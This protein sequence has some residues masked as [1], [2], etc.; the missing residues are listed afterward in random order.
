MYFGLVIPLCFL[1]LL[2]LQDSV[3]KKRKRSPFSEE[4]VDALETLYHKDP[5]PSMAIKKS[6]AT[7]M[8]LEINQLNRWF[9]NRRRKARRSGELPAANKSKQQ[10]IK[11]MGLPSGQ[12]DGN[13]HCQF[14]A[15]QQKSEVVPLIVS[16]LDT[17]EGRASMDK[18]EELKEDDLNLLLELEKEVELL[19]SK[20]LSG[21]LIPLPPEGQ[22]EITA[23]S[24]SRL[25]ALIAG[26]TKPLSELVE[27]LLPL[28]T[29]DA[30]SPALSP[31]ELRTNILNL[32]ARK[33]HDVEERKKAKSVQEQLEARGSLWQWELRDGGRFLSKIQRT[34]AAN[35]KR[36][37]H[38]VSSRMST[39]CTAI[40]IIKKYRDGLC[41]YEVVKKTVAS[42][43]KSK[44]FEQLQDA[45][46]AE[47]AALQ[48]K[49]EILQRDKEL[50]ESERIKQAAAKEKLRQEKEKE[51][52]LL[53][54]Q[55][56][57]ERER[58]RLQKEEEK[59]NLRRQREEEKEELRRQKEEERERLK[60]KREEEKELQRREKEKEKERK[61]AEAEAAK[62]ARKTGFK[63]A[64][65]LS[66]TAN[67][68][69]SFFSTPSSVDRKEKCAAREP[70]FDSSSKGKDKSSIH[71]R[72]SETGSC[73]TK[74]EERFPKPPTDYL[75]PRPILE[76]LDDSIDAAHGS[77]ANSDVIESEWN[78][79]V[80]RQI[81]MRKKKAN[82]P[83]RTLGL[84]PSWARYPDAYEAA[85]KRLQYVQESGIDDVPTWRRKLLQFSD[86][87]R[88][89]YYGSWHQSRRVVGPR[90]PF[91]RD[92]NIDYE[93]MSD[94]EW[95]E[96]PED[97]DD[98]GNSDNEEENEDD[99]DD[100]EQGSFM[101]EDGYLSESEGVKLDVEDL[102][103]DFEGADSR[104]YTGNCSALVSDQRDDLRRKGYHL[105][106][107]QLRRSHATGKPL[108]I[109]R[110][111]SHDTLMLDKNAELVSD[112]HVGKEKYSSTIQGDLA[113]L[114]ALSMEVLNPSILIEPP[115]EIAHDEEN[116]PNSRKSPENSA[117]KAS[118]QECM[119][120]SDQ[121]SGQYDALLPDLAKFVVANAK[122]TKPLLVEG[123]VAANSNQ[124]IPKKWVNK[125]ITDIAERVHGSYKLK[126][127]VLQENEKTK[128]CS[129]LTEQ[130]I[131]SAAPVIQTEKSKDSP[132][133]KCASTEGPLDR[134]LNKNAGHLEGN[135]TTDVSVK[136]QLN[137]G[138]EDS[139]SKNAGKLSDADFKDIQTT[140]K[141]LCG[142]PLKSRLCC[143]KIPDNPIDSTVDEFWTALLQH[144][145]L[146]EAVD[147]PL[148]YI[149]F[150]KRKEIQQ[151]V[152]GMPA[153]I[154]AALLAAAKRFMKSSEMY[155]C[156]LQVME[157][158]KSVAEALDQHK[159]NVSL[160]SSASQ[161]AWGMLRCGPTAAS[162][163]ELAKEPDISLVLQS[164]IL[165][166]KCCGA[167]D[168]LGICIILARDPESRYYMF[169]NV[170]GTISG[171]NSDLCSKD[172]LIEAI[173]KIL[174]NCQCPQLQ[175]AACKALKCI[176]TDSPLQYE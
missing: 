161:K 11:D 97:G 89:G 145:D 158:L 44:S 165:K 125:A 156:C 16:E 18:P 80:H 166:G 43:D 132:P 74:F 91:G 22:V 157:C 51:K 123:F 6:L 119:L 35:I 171:M 84:P 38:A 147:R 136:L 167:V 5:S 150:F 40:A 175:D 102:P 54:I 98:L 9:E 143:L 120:V 15:Q 36:R 138:N 126:M 86:S 142:R 55:K 75:V 41:P 170:S 111:T 135:K 122:W 117:E 71:K 106:K 174:K 65:E 162:L 141:H 68:F 101:V 85:V 159:K 95:E 153:Y 99:C 114:T 127:N 30:N 24:D 46:Q 33:C 149:Y 82:A 137:F 20:G 4:Q 110:S 173:N 129:P 112:G 1:S 13:N 81:S 61:V 83:P 169:D 164:T 42:L 104:E 134:L 76:P 144:I 52:E 32:A 139:P 59:E 172:P 8:G 66:K 34:T 45:A 29:S 131:N 128:K 49:L 107:E 154:P 2:L 31:E 146:D 163:E 108:I 90:N 62:I 109:V 160:Q 39:V 14:S 50:K 152:S 140:E 25:S 103:D 63:H 26:Q 148:T 87:V 3:S 77:L 118:V 88:P 37:A 23:Y 96:E 12:S 130:T 72:A 57:E 70:C 116:Q 21:P 67:K 69:R 100:C 113:I 94:M 56:E 58:L 19:R 73:L 10:N 133:K 176:I 53:R 28:L 64:H 48:A 121:G 47:D 168:A 17:G 155:D 27:A 92:P 105:L 124:K 151:H 7:S 60:R 115:R 78:S 93:T 79:F